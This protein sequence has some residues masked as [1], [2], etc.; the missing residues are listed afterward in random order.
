MEY[1]CA[2]A[3]L[4]PL[5]AMQNYTVCMLQILLVSEACVKSDALTLVLS[6][7]VSFLL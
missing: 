2:V 1:F 7:T 6:A 4:S 5:Q 3:L